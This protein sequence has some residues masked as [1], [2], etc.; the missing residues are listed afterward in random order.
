MARKFELSDEHLP[1]DIRS[2]V[3]V[4]DIH[5]AS[6][7]LVVSVWREGENDARALHRAEVI[8]S[9]LTWAESLADVRA[10]D[11]VQQRAGE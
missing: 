8:K 5:D 11:N 9:A 10:A 7:R 4:H 6:G 3:L 1:L 2:S